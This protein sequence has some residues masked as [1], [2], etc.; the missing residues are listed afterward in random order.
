M[1]RALTQ[2]A[3]D[4]LNPGA[5]RRE[6]PDGQLRGLFLIVQP[7]GKMAWAVRYRHYGRSR[8]LTIGG[9][10]EISLKDARAAAMRALSSIAER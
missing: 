10:P 6:I 7:S 4:K 8:K 9:Y 3:I 2:L 1:A 5:V